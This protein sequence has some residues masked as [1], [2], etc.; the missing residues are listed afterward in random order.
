MKDLSQPVFRGEVS[1]N[2]RDR[3]GWLRP[4]FFAEEISLAT[5]YARGTEPLCCVL[6]GERHLDLTEPDPMNPDHR[7]VVQRLTKRFDEWTCRYSGEERDAWSYLEAGDLYHYEG[8]G[9]AGRWNALFEVALDEL[10]F[11]AVRVLDCTDSV[12]LTGQP[13]TIWITLH[14]DNIRMATPIEEIRSRLRLVVSG[15]LNAA[16]MEAWLARRHPDLLRR[17][18]RL[19]DM[20]E[21]PN[22]DQLIEQGIVPAPLTR[23]VTIRHREPADRGPVAVGAAVSLCPPHIDPESPDA[24]A[25]TLSNVSP[26]DLYCADGDGGALIY[27]PKAWRGDGEADPV[28]HLAGLDDER[29]QVLVDGENASI[30]AHQ[31]AIKTINEHI[32]TH[33]FCPDSSGY[34]HGPDHWKRVSRNGR[35]IARS[36]GINPLL[37]H[38]FGLVHD[39]QRWDDGFDPQHGPRAAAFIQ[40]TRASLFYFLSEEQIQH[41]STACDLHSNGVTQGDKSLQACW[42]ADRLDLWRCDIEPDPELLCTPYAQRRHTILSALEHLVHDRQ[43]A[44]FDAEES[45]YQWENYMDM[46]QRA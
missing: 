31:E 2:L 16:D 40:E 26:G 13:S 22:L 8:T 4:F 9:E 10:G 33:A 21:C 34:H 39:S 37:P 1:G 28:S 19:T 23:Q 45:E 11:D 20:E 29:L 15:D 17:A 7:Q 30:L 44:E 38:I 6:Q 42:D 5:S 14:R 27:L 24:L 46:R 3:G 18:K 32:M 41:L 25:S 12:S 36:L 43:N 35:A